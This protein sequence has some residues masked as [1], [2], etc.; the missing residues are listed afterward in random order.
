MQRRCSDCGAGYFCLV[1]VRMLTFSK[2][3]YNHITES[4]QILSKT[5]VVAMIRH[6]QMLSSSVEMEENEIYIYVNI[7]QT[8]LLPLCC[9]HV[10]IQ[11][12]GSRCQT[13]L[14]IE[15]RLHIAQQTSV[16]LN[17]E[18]CQASQVLG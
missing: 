8:L 6:A 7:Y 5:E 9:R 16:S 1:A 4:I 15:D 10:T 14:Q 3:Y 11:M 2:C 17:L 12:K 13:A 18:V